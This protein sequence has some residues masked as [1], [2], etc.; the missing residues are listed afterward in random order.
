MVGVAVVL[1]VGVVASVA[2]VLA[3]GTGA[4]RP[5][6]AKAPGARPAKTS[7]GVN[8][9]A[10]LTGPTVLGGGFAHPSAVATDGTDVWVVNGTSVT[11][12]SAATGA[13]VKLTSGQ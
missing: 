6:A 3:S 9:R 4:A 13:L 2:S 12:L 7:S 8:V 11:E 1:A 5:R 10:A